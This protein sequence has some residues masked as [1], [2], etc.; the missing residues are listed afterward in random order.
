MKRNVLQLIGSFH[1]GGSELQAV[2]LT[3]LLHERSN[4][5]VRVAC[6]DPT[7]VLRDEVDRMQIE[8]ATYPLT[9]FHDR[10]F[11]VQL[12]RFAAQLR[13][14]HIHIVHTHDFYTNVFGIAAAR[15]AG[16][17][18][19]IASRRQTARRSRP[20][21]LVE[22]TA[23]RF[24]HGIV[25]NC[26]AAR[27]E[28]IREGVPAGKI[29]TIHN[30][31][32]FARVAPRVEGDD[33]LTAFGL[34][35]DRRFVT[36]VA[37]MRLSMKGHAMFLRAALRVK[38]SIPDAAFVIAGEGE[39]TDTMRELA[40]RFGLANDVFF[41][42]HCDR[43]AELLALSDVCVLSSTS[44]G[45][46]NSILEY[47]AASRPVVSTEVGGAREAIVDG[48]TGYLVPAGD[49]QT[50]AQRIVWLLCHPG[51]ARK[52]GELGRATVE[53]KFSSEAQLER[54]LNLYNRLFAAVHAETRRAK[55]IHSELT[56]G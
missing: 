41:I 28:L 42:G 9:S 37:N 36:I 45:F 46:S 43:V 18:V 13:K 40:A 51:R 49:D 4:Y 56:R 17:P 11:V 35:R 8:V 20:Q 16:V 12:C 47:M 54:T 25:A 39:P 5:D 3:G 33:A 38:G 19:R 32:D 23:Y 44:E 31:L 1:Q 50:M 29:S 27:G 26:E 14:H 21:R 2:Q 52:M 53:Q 34:P 7:G 22:R 24:S 6:L 10:N 15:L 30:G 55:E 48:E